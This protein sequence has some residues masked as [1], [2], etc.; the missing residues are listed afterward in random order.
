MAVL[1]VNGSPAAGVAV[2]H[3]AGSLSALD[4]LTHYFTYAGMPVVSSIYWDSLL[5]GEDDRF[6]PKVLTELGH[7][8]ALMARG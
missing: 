6:G 5:H 1:L 7:R 2:A 3:R 4:R 8:M